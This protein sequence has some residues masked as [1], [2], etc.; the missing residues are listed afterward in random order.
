MRELA[1]KEWE[2]DQKTNP[3]PVNPDAYCYG[4]IA[5]LRLIVLQ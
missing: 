2:N 4:F 1:M 5:A 3:N